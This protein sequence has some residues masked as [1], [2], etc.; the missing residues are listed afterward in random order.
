MQFD[1]KIL[2]ASLMYLIIGGKDLMAAFDIEYNLM[3]ETFIVRENG[4]PILEDDLGFNTSFQLPESTQIYNQL[5]EPFFLK[6]FGISLMEMRPCVKFVVKYFIMDIEHLETPDQIVDPAI[7][8][9]CMQQKQNQ[10]QQIT[11]MVGTTSL[12][13]HTS[14][15]L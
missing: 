14:E 13:V 15:V 4:F 3:Y 10:V 11:Q 5:V 1:P 2:V 9:Q 8:E 6:E 12:K 7:L